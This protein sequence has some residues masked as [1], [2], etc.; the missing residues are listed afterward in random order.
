MERGGKGRRSICEG[1]FNY[2]ESHVVWRS[3]RVSVT[4]RS[5]SSS[6]H[7]WMRRRYPHSIGA[8]SKLSF[9]AVRFTLPVHLLARKYIFLENIAVTFYSSDNNLNYYS[10]TYCYH[11]L[12]PICILSPTIVLSSTVH[13][14]AK[15]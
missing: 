10:N 9:T 5:R 14:L 13:D 12:L 11:R 3:S 6:S 4:W 7:V 8:V 1:G 2:Y 15:A